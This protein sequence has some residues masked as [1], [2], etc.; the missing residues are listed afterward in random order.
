MLR[1]IVISGTTGVTENC[2]IYEWNGQMLIVD[3]GVGF[4]DPEMLG[5]DLVIPDFTYIKKN[6]EN[7]KGIL[8]SHA[9]EDH[10]GSLPFLFKEVEAPIYSTKLVAGFIEDK[11]ADYG[12]KIPKINVFNPERDSFTVGPFK[13]TPFRVSHSVPDGVGY[14]IDTPVGRIFHVPDYKFDWTP[15]D[16]RPFDISKAA[17]LASGGVLALA[18]DCLG[19]TTEGYTKSEKEIET[20]VEI[21]AKSASKKILFTTISSNISRIKQAF[22]VAAKL[23]RKVVIVGRSIEKKVEIA[24][25]LGYLDYPKDLIISPKDAKRLPEN[26][27]FYVISGSYGQIGSALYRVAISDHQFISVNA[28]DVVIF[29][30]DPAPPG[31]K[32]NVDFVVDRLIELGVDVHYY[33]TQ[34]DLHV[35]G[36]GSQEDIKTLFGIVRPKYFIP[37]GGTIR[38]MRAY[39]S[40]THDFGSPRDN[41][42]ELKD[43]EVL[44]I[45][46]KGARL[47]PEKVP[48]KSVMVD[49]LGVGDVGNI[50]LRDRNVLANEGVVI[51]VIGVGKDTKKLNTTPDIISRGFVFKGAKES[52]LRDASF[53]LEK[54]LERMKDLDAKLAR[55]V[56]IDFLEK[57]FHKK[58]ARHPMILPVVVEV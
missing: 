56:T 46:S 26:G 13:I 10:L 16:G 27:V 5:V 37:I 23:G 31:S 58:I 22:N 7:L 12:M 21:I 4:P 39:K 49:G 25:R 6:K 14:S 41:V 53:G 42:F 48:S 52:L 18:S 57:F 11:F 2:F 50:V 35:S 28:N 15:V 55:N 45:D 3:C 36:H 51:V 43:G 9:H 54:E 29:S 20:K 38:H 47:L 1:F 8:I 17:V 24:R 30:G 34:D 33:D 19:S 40:I 32:D 44:G